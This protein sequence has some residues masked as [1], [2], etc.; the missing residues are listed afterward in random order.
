MLICW[1]RDNNERAISA[2]K[3]TKQVNGD[4]TIG[5]LLAIGGVLCFS[6]RPILIKLAYAWSQDPVTLLALRMAF[7]APFFA[8]VAIWTRR[9]GAANPLSSRDMVYVVRSAC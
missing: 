2:N 9:N 7:A 6:L 4:W 1:K 3:S 5:L 8:G